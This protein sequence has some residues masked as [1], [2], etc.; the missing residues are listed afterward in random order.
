ME[1][2]LFGGQDRQEGS[3]VGAVEDKI[4]ERFGTGAI[5]RGSSRGHAE[6]P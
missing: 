4:K 1:G 3:R 5:R 6:H 2:M